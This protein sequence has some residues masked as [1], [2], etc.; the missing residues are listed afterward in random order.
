MLIDQKARFYDLSKAAITASGSF[1]DTIDLQATGYHGAGEPL[2]LYAVAKD[3]DKANSNETYSITLEDASA[4]HATTG[5]LTTGKADVGPTLTFDRDAVN[6]DPGATG[7]ALGGDQF[8][9][10]ALPPLE[11]IARYVGI[12]AT[13]GGTSPSFRLEAWLSY[14]RPENVNVV[15]ADAISWSANG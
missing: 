2:Y 10:A 6:A 3:M 1:G 15:Y 14:T 8:K 5:A 9:A 7:A 11:N 4:V 13:V 12:K